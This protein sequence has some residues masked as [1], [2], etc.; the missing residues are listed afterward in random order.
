MSES[1]P[2]GGPGGAVVNVSSGSAVSRPLLYAMSKG[3]LN[4]F[5]A[6]A[7][8]ELAAPAFAS[9]RYPRG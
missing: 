4:S 1:Q 2:A 9:T 6:G 8:D 7:V 5:Q 3:A